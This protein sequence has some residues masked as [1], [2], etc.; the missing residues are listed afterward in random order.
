MFRRREARGRTKRSILEY[1]SIG[2]TEQRQSMRDKRRVIWGISSA[3]RAPALHAGGQ[4]FDPLILHHGESQTEWHIERCVGLTQD[5]VPMA[6]QSQGDKRQV[7]STL[8]TEQW[9]TY[10]IIKWKRNRGVHRKMDTQLTLRSFSKTER[11]NYNFKSM[12]INRETRKT[13]LQSELT[14]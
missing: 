4:E 2:S 6:R 11:V 13:F 5:F 10:L 7:R 14:M 1:V 8:K 3:G 12:K 9:I